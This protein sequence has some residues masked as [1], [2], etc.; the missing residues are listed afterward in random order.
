[1]LGQ[2]LRGL[3]WLLWNPYFSS[4]GSWSRKDSVQLVDTIRAEFKK[5]LSKSG[6]SWIGMWR[7]EMRRFQIGG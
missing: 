1:M 6:G 5:I 4:G 3:G 2:A 7:S